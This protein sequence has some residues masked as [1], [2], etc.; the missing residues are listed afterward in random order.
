MTT[1]DAWLTVL[2]LV[3]AGLILLTAAGLVSDALAPR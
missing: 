1:R 3:L 2:A